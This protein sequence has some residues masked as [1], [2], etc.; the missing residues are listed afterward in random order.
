MSEPQLKKLIQKKMKTRKMNMMTER[1][2]EST[3]QSIADPEPVEN[4][5][6]VQMIDKD[7]VKS[8]IQ[9]TMGKRHTIVNDQGNEIDF[10]GETKE[11]FIKACEEGYPVIQ[12]TLNSVYEIGKLLFE[13]RSKLKKKI[14]GSARG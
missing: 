7:Q 12:R 4:E 8:M 9:A 13:V 3:P 6:P 14:R 11:D 5:K 1:A 10:G 2:I